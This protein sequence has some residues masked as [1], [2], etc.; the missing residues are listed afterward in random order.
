MTAY[1]AGN[2][3]TVVILSCLWFISSI[4]VLTKFL[5]V[6]GGLAAAVVGL[7]AIVV[8]MTWVRR[9]QEEGRTVIRPK[10]LLWL[11]G[12]VFVAFAVLYPIAKSGVVGVG[13]DRDDGINRAVM[14]LFHG[15]NPYYIRTYLGNPL[16]QMP[17][18]L[19]L[20]APFRLVLGNSAFQSLFWLPVFVWFCTS[21]FRRPDTVALF[22]CAAV[23]QVGALHEVVVGGDYLINALYVALAV[24]AVVWVHEREKPAL[25]RLA[26][27][28]FLALA[29]CSRPPYIVV[30]PVVAAYVL[31]RSGFARAL[32]MVFAVGLAA[33]ALV[34]P[35]YLY[36]PSNF[37]PLWLAHHLSDLPAALHATITIPLVGIGIACAS[38]FVRLTEARVYGMIFAALAPLFLPEV[39]AIWLSQGWKP[40][41]LIDGNFVLPLSVFGGL[42]LMSEFERANA[43]A[44]RPAMAANPS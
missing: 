44:A 33:L 17:G 2:I 35:F 34:A 6:A 1:V 38:V 11:V 15:T 14:A 37:T 24:H 23:V 8:A 41:A 30:V 10:H 5:G 13:S 16:T 25:A 21:F 29:I 4:G 26:A 40:E 7:A 18:A 9:L 28:I 43:G 42:W 22:V 20:A 32:E 31:R 39:A 36:D 19:L 12:G 27:A 3:G